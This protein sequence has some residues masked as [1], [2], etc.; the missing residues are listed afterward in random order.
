MGGL[1]FLKISYSG[2]LNKWSWV[3]K[4][5]RIC[6]PGSPLLPSAKEYTEWVF[7]GSD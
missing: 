6:N 4:L 2:V 1:G 5:S 7:S 3:V